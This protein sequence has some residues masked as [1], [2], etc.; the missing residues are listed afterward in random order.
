MHERSLPRVGQ[1]SGRR[2]NLN[3]AIERLSCRFYRRLLRPP[4]S[5]VNSFGTY[6]G[7]IDDKKRRVRTAT[8]TPLLWDFDTNQCPTAVVTMEGV[9]RHG[10]KTILPEI[11]GPQAVRRRLITLKL[12]RCF[13]R[14]LGFPYAGLNCLTPSSSCS[15]AWPS[16]GL[17]KNP[18]RFFSAKIFIPFTV[19]LTCSQQASG[20]PTST[21]LALTGI[22][23]PYIPTIGCT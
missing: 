3:P 15:T 2:S 14:S 22:P 18:T 7:N 6:D 11:L 21:T 4:R 1:H 12:H 8:A 5:L 9:V 20:L 13:G 23:L 17:K 16:D 10:R 19:T